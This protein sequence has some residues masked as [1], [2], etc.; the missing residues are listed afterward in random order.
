MTAR[1]A[2]R[3]LAHRAEASSSPEHVRTL[4]ASSKT[5]T[6]EYSTH[7]C[8]DFYAYRGRVGTQEC[9][10]HLAAITELNTGT[11]VSLGC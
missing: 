8:H 10:N 5:V 2:S 6:L 3:F 1:R 7:T 9:R 4:R 11:P